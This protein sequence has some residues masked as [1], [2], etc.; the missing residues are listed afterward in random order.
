MESRFS[1]TRSTAIPV[2]S[3]HPI[4]SIGF[5]LRSTACSASVSVCSEAASF[6][7]RSY[8][9]PIE[10]SCCVTAVTAC[11]VSS[12]G[13]RHPASPFLSLSLIRFLETK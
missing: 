3:T 12:A 8:C 10:S 11:S 5:T 2:A 4:S 7:R 9:T 13:R 1:S 6:E